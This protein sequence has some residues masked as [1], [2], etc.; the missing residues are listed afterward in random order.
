MGECQIAD[1]FSRSPPH[2]TNTLYLVMLEGGD[3]IMCDLT[4]EG[5]VAVKK[6]ES[7]NV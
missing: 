6:I 7:Q 3:G 5:G 4:I 2:T 1:S